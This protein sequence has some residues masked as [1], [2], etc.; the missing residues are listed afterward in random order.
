MFPHL[1]GIVI[2]RLDRVSGVLQISGRSVSPTAAC[3]ACGVGSSRVHSR[4]ERR[5][6]DLAVS[7]EQ[8]LIRLIA[9]RFV[10]LNPA[11]RRKTFAEQVPDLTRRH[12]RRSQSLTASLESIALALAG[13]AGARLAKALGLPVS[14]TTLLRLIRAL[15]E[16]PVTAP[17]VLGVDDFALRRGKVYGTVL[18]D[19]DT[20][21]PIDLLIG[22][23]GHTLA[24][25]LSA[26]PGVEVICRDRA[27]GYAEG[28]GSAAPEAIQVADR[29]H[30]WHNLI[31]AVEKCVIHHRACLREPAPPAEP[32][33]HAEHEQ[34]PHPVTAG[35]EMETR[36][37][38]RIRERYALIQ[39][40]LAQGYGIKPIARQ[41]GLARGT[42]QRYARATTVQ[43]KLTQ[44]ARP[45]NLDAFKPYLHERFTS[46]TTR[47][48]RL[49]EE[50]HA[51]GY[52]GSYHN[53]RDYIRRLRLWAQT[54]PESAPP[55][56]IHAVVTWITKHPDNLD[57]DDQ[58]ALDR[59]LSRCPELTVLIEHVR[60]FAIMMSKRRGDQLT[61]WLTRAASSDL[62]GLNSF[63]RGIER[64]RAAVTAGLTLPWNSGPVEGHVNRIKML[65]R[66]MFGRANFDL[67][68]R[69]VLST[70]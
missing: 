64:D 35:I 48:I 53:V 42:V 32:H 66:Q 29:W 68:R 52:S 22:R 11:C 4:Y 19:M 37:N 62:P 61:Q 39:E 12:G 41:L 8:V 10:C 58:Q 36:L 60:Q 9:R 13:R 3:T 63:I 27:A 5:L 1:R 34:A 45:S 47:P 6:D 33:G 7:G 50:I 38:T 23:D 56:P 51:Q 49:F 67:L 54:R 70:T 20:R 25:W 46:G 28:A 59:I 17:V 57:P 18:V 14:R 43:D 31:E 40:L 44:A 24:A 69:R 26:H 2:D 65:K 55:P 15:P 16:L 30:L 21:R